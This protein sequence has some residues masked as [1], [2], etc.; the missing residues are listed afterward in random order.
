MQSTLTA[1]QLER[2]QTLLARWAPSV[3]HATRASISQYV[4]SG[5]RH[6]SWITQYYLHR[7]F[8][9]AP[10]L[11]E[12]S[13]VVLNGFFYYAGGILFALCHHD[14]LYKCHGPRVYV[15]CEDLI[16]K[17]SLICVI[18]DFLLDRPDTREMTKTQLGALL[19]Q[20][21]SGALGDTPKD[22]DPRVASVFN[23]LV[24]LVRTVPQSIPYVLKAFQAEVQSEIQAM[25]GRVPEQPAT[26]KLRQIE[27]SKT[28]TACELLG[29]CLN[30][31]TVIPIPPTL[32]VLVQIF[33]DL[34]DMYLD[35]AEGITTLVLT[36]L[37]QTGCLDRIIYE[38]FD[39]ID[40][41][42]SHYWLFKIFSACFTATLA[43]ANPYVSNQVTALTYPYSILARGKD[44]DASPI[45]RDGILTHLRCNGVC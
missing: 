44:Y 34:A 8:K 36:E 26:D 5:M 3:D 22:V 7:A 17:F 13:E 6:S 43:N 30:K 11:R 25:P 16:F 29:V 4:I 39:A 38:L 24:S 23:L 20:L 28:I 37:Q 15:V 14:L 41:L 21:L 10:W 2:L 42:P 33:D 45:L 1:V 27:M 31:G 35:R 18:T 19:R 9:I 32:G 12:D 40:A